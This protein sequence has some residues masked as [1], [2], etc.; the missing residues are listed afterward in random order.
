[1]FCQA[2]RGIPAVLSFGEI[3]WDVFGD[4]EVIGGAPFNVAAHLARLG[5]RSS[6]YSRVGRDLRGARAM[7]CVHR[8]GIN[9]RWLQSDAERP[10]GWV[11]ITLDRSGQPTFRIGSDTAWDAIE[12]PTTA[13]V[14]DL[15]AESFST[16]VCG[17]LAQRSAP[18]RRALAAIRAALPEVPIFYDVNLRGA[19]TPIERVRDT[20]PGVAFLKVNE[21]E[22]AGLALA[23]FGRGLKD[24]ALFSELRLHYGVRA[25]LCTRGAHGCTVQVEGGSFVSQAAPVKAVSAVGAGDAFSAAFLASWVQGLSLEQA[26][27]NANVLGAFVAASPETVP[28]YSDALRAKLLGLGEPSEMRDSHL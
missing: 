15:R 10:T 24:E 7:Q 5:I 27:A 4:K 9:D 28:E 22:A 25:L 20:L 2:A 26:T 17:T 19:E 14:A 3:L 21:E 12:P 1:M 11:S 8:F 13:S 16:I 23:L 18:S 6:T